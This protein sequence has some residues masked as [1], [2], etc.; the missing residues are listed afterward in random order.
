[1]FLDF[2]FNMLFYSHYTYLRLDIKSIVIKFADFSQKFRSHPFLLEAF[3]ST[4]S[5]SVILLSLRM[6]ISAAI[7]TGLQSAAFITLHIIGP[8]W[9]TSSNMSNNGDFRFSKSSIIFP[10]SSPSTAWFSE[11]SNQ[12]DSLFSLVRQVPRMYFLTFF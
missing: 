3:S 7:S 8:R 11:N 10:N 9:D 6:V 1:M 2:D 12:Y 5:I 4:C